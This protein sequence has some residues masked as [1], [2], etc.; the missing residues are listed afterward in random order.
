MTE[1]LYTFDSYI[2]EFEAVVTQID[3]EN[4]AIVLDK[5]AFYPGGGG[6]PFDLGEL[7]VEDRKLYI[8]KVKKIGELVFHYT[9]GALPTVGKKVKGKIDWGRRNKLM[10]THTSLH[11]LSGVIWR[12]YQAQ[13]T[14]GNMD[15][16]KGRLDFELGSLGAELVKEIEKRVNEVVK[17]ELNV[18]VSVLPREEAF[19]IPDLIRTKINLVPESLTEIRVVDVENFDLQADGGTHVSNT[20]EIGEIKISKYKSKGK[21][22]KRIE[23]TLD[24][25]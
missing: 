1:L 14:G 17:K 25:K 10:R 15:T 5:T 6:Q 11:I 22:N 7:I 8:Y 2:K 13:T 4:S 21:I 20:R 24:A 12:Y 9:E 3:E 18:N 23:I 16:T 19:Q